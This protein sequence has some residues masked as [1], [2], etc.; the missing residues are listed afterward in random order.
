M[1]YDINNVFA[2]ILRNEIKCS[3]V[4]ENDYALAFYDIQPRAKI[5]VLVI[6][7]VYVK[8]FDEF[9]LQDSNIVAEYYRAIYT[10]IEFLPLAEGYRLISNNKINGGQEIQHFHTH[11]LGGQILGPM[12]SC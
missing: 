6:P 3:K 12:I 11:I 2:K 1:S 7:K 4:Y 10:T 5:H 9:I 8:S